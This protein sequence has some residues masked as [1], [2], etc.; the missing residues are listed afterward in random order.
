MNANFYIRF[1]AYSLSRCPVVLEEASKRKN[2]S[3]YIPFRSFKESIEAICPEII[4]D[5][6]VIMGEG[7]TLSRAE[8]SIKCTAIFRQLITDQIKN[9]GFNLV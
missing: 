9:K 8:E 7:I 4:D 1:W 5:M 6:K 3:F 2:P